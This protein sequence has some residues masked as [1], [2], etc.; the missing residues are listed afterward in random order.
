MS[1]DDVIADVEA[2]GCQ[3]VEVTG[4]EPLLQPMCIR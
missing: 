2:R 4:G 3:T 1:V